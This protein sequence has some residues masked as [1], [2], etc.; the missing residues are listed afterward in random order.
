MSLVFRYEFDKCVSHYD[1]DYKVNDFSC[2][3]QFLNMIFGQLT[4]CESI[5]DIITCLK[6][7]Q[8]IVNQNETVNVDRYLLAYQMKRYLDYITNG[9]FYEFE[10]QRELTKWSVKDYKRNFRYF[11]E[12]IS[13]SANIRTIRTDQLQMEH[14]ELFHKYKK[15]NLLR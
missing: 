15:E 7:R 10:A 5:R 3:N 1:G 6:V 12:S 2:W 14:I 4:H 11:I 8:N 9:G 13:G